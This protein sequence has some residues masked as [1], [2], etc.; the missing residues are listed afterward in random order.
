VSVISAGGDQRVALRIDQ[1]AFIG[2]EGAHI[3]G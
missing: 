2:G 1:L 3:A